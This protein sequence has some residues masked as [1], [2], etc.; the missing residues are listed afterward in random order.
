MLTE[1][2]DGHTRASHVPNI[3]LYVRW[4][5]QLNIVEQVVVVNM[6]SVVGS[7]VT[8]NP[9]RTYLSREKTPSP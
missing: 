5:V 1:A 2:I 9:T 8:Q 3:E 4:H 6:L 7:L